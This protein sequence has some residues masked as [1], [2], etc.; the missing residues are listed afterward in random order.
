M[1][2]QQNRNVIQGSSFLVMA[3]IW[4]WG[5]TD[6]PRYPGGPT[7]QGRARQPAAPTDATVVLKSYES[8]ELIPIGPGGITQAEC[9]IDGHEVSYVIDG[10]Y[11]QEIGQYRVGLFVTLPDGRTKIESMI[12]RVN[13]L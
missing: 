13:A 8:E 4:Q 10:E 9:D 11:L 12:L 2:K 3:Y 1:A 7:E 6:A 5:K